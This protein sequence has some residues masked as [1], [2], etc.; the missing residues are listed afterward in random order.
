MPPLF[1][2]VLTSAENILCSPTNV[3]RSQDK[4]RPLFDLEM[5]VIQPLI[6]PLSNVVIRIYAIVVK[7]FFIYAGKRGSGIVIV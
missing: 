1:L 7:S 5:S 3:L 4:L 6:S 2:E